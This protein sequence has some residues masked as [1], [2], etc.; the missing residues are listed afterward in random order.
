[1]LSTLLLKFRRMRGPIEFVNDL[2]DRDYEYYRNYIARRL[3]FND[4]LRYRKNFE[5]L[6]TDNAL[7]IYD[8]ADYEEI[9]Q[10]VS[11]T[12]ELGFKIGWW[13]FERITGFLYSFLTPLSYFNRHCSRR[14]QVP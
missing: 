14:F 4:T 5:P 13:S 7:A 2:I 10:R 8:K 9:G 1:M 12:T 3:L 6:P 11:Q